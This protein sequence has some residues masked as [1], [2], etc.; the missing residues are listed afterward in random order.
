[1]HYI[2]LRYTIPKYFLYQTSMVAKKEKIVSPFDKSITSV[3]KKTNITSADDID[4]DILVL[5][6]KVCSFE[7]FLKGLDIA[8]TGFHKK[9]QILTETTTFEEG[10][11]MIK[12]LWPYYRYEFSNILFR[13]YWFDHET[14]GLGAKHIAYI[15]YNFL[16]DIPVY[17]SE[18]WRKGGERSDIF[19]IWWKNGSKQGV[20]LNEYALDEYLNREEVQM[21]YEARQQMKQSMWVHWDEPVNGD[22]FEIIHP[23]MFYDINR[24]LL[25]LQEEFAQIVANAP[26]QLTFTEI[27]NDLATIMEYSMQADKDADTLETIKKNKNIASLSTETQK[28]L[29]NFLDAFTNNLFPAL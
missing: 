28:D 1:M 21:E 6:D 20:I 5:T 7:D 15:V 10:G 12:E 4:N 19:E 23:I 25:K 13:A 14:G 3:K 27:A 2:D 18:I 24:K 17:T 11:Y 16:L 8:W 26:N 29:A 22:D 9:A